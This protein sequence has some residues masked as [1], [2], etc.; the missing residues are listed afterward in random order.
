MISYWACWTGVVD[1][2]ACDRIIDRG[3]K[4][5]HQ[6]A[7]IGH[8]DNSRLSLNYRSTK[9]GWFDRIKDRDIVD[10]I[11][12]YATEANREFFGFDI[13]HGIFEMQFT[14]YNA[15]EKAKYDWHSDTMFKINRRSDRKLSFVLQL[16]DPLEYDGGSFEFNNVDNAVFNQKDFLPKGSVIVFPS[17]LEHRVTEV[18]RGTRY[19]LVSWIEGPK[20]R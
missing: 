6:S 19:S 13:S 2:H 7:G 20:W 10:L 15:N 8:D 18:T 11:T 1:H 9:I 5:K 3:L 14:M 16:S 17:V 12:I 4:L